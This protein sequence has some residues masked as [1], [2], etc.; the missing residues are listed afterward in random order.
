MAHAQSWASRARLMTWLAVPAVVAA[1]LVAFAHP[2][3]AAADTQR[4]TTPGVPVATFPASGAVTLTWTPSTDNVGVTGYTVSR[5]YIDFCQS[6]STATN[7]ITLNDQRPSDTYL[8]GVQALDAA[9]NVSNSVSL[10]V[11]MPP[12]DPIP[13][14]RPGRP[15]ATLVTDTALTLNWTAATDN[16]RLEEHQIIRIDGATETI[17]GHA[18]FFFFPNSFRLSGLSPTTTYTFA[19]RARDA[20]GNEGPT[21]ES[22]T[23][24]TTA[25]GVD[26]LPPSTPTNLMT[27]NVTTT[28]LRLTWTASTDNVGVTQYNITQAYTDIVTLRTSTTNFIDITGLSPSRTYN[29]IVSARDAAG[30]SSNGAFLKITMPPGDSQP[31]TAPGT[32]VPSDLTDTA[33]TLTWT[34]STDNIIVEAYDIYRI[35]DNGTTLVFATTLS[36]PGPPNFIRLGNLVT[37]TPYRFAVRARDAAGN[38]SPLS[39]SVVVT[40]G[41]PP[42]TTPPPTSPCRA[43]WRTMSQWPGGFTA[44]IVVQN[45]SSGTINGWTVTFT[46]PGGQSITN[47]W[48][49][50]RTGVGP[51]V[52]VRNQ[53]WNGTLPPNGT[54][55]FGFQATGSPNPIPSPITCTSP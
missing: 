23:V 20:A 46:F 12:G 7:S 15:F 27:V 6:F 44:E 19:V 9:G 54:T 38:I 39:G 30:N 52:I 33:V 32:P 49:G 21:S 28:S 26:T 24:T 34:R 18:T 8:F 37:G 48:N 43:T 3:Q 42:P 47:L 25:P 40:P 45:I 36:Y 1:T 5:C 31:P 53:P 55:S 4:P 51:T 35:Q 11:T 14:T 50:I 17:V 29:F 2:G 16:V 41:G 22:V 13:P 10:R